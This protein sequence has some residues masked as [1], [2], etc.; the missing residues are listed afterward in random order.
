[1]ETKFKIG[2]LV[3]LTQTVIKF[4]ERYGIKLNPN[5]IGEV[6]QFNLAWNCVTYLVKVEDKKIWVSEDEIEKLH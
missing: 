6:L 5:N 2:E 1:M 4:Y 3:R